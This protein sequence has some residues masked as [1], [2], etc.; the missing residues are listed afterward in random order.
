MYQMCL[1]PPKAVRLF[2]LVISFLPNDYP[3]PMI[4]CCYP[5]YPFPTPFID[6]GSTNQVNCTLHLIYLLIPCFS[7]LCAQAILFSNYYLKY[8][9]NFGHFASDSRRCCSCYQ[10]FSSLFLPAIFLYSRV[11]HL[12][13]R[14]NCL[15]C[16]TLMCYFNHYPQCLSYSFRSLLYYSLSYPYSYS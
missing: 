12:S 16:L 2:V 3:K 1:Y 15:K 5:R 4:V 8:F 10:Q 9:S 14:F 6:S 11:N 7:L 13:P